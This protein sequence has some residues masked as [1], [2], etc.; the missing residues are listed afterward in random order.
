LHRPDAATRAIY[1]E[2]AQIIVKRRVEQ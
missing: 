2:A 1:D